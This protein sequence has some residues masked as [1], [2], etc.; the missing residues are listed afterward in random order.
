MVQ[1]LLMHVLVIML[2]RQLDVVLLRMG[3]QQVPDLFLR[4]CFPRRVPR[5]V[6]VVVEQAFRVNAFIVASMSWIIARRLNR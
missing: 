1:V 4:D 6:S 5:V 3:V 2:P